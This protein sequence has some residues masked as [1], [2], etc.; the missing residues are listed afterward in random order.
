M[1]K[2][3]EMEVKR[4]IIIKTVAVTI[5]LTVPT[6]LWHIFAYCIFT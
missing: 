5:S 6:S 1:E 2:L 4:R 3:E